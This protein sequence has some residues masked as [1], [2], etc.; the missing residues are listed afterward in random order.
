LSETLRT[1]D[2]N[3]RTVFLHDRMMPCVAFPSDL[4]PLLVRYL[5]VY[6]SNTEH[7]TLAALAL[8]SHACL[9]EASKALYSTAVIH[10][11]I[12]QRSSEH[13]QG[14]S[15]TVS[16]IAM[17]DL[18]KMERQLNLN[19]ISEEEEEEYEDEDNEEEGDDRS[20][21]SL[22]V[23]NWTSI[24]LCVIPAPTS[25]GGSNPMY[26]D[27]PVLLPLSLRGIEILSQP[28]ILEVSR[29]YLTILHLLMPVSD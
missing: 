11:P 3:V 20:S 13:K 7:R 29:A 27:I 21:S 12:S 10:S 9:R 14:P 17:M 6:S 19:S 2:L 4:L 28:S 23:S 24:G 18:G 15:R 16:K 25:H 1:L 22:V 5:D 8:V 26:R